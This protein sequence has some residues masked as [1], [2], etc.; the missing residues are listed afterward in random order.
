MRKMM[1]F[2]SAV[3][4]A[5]SLQAG[6][7]IWGFGG[8]ADDP[9]GA[10]GWMDS[11]ATALLYLGNVSFD[12]ASGWDLSSATF[13]TSSGYDVATDMGFG[14]LDT[15]NRS[16]SDAVNEAG[17][18]SY[19]L[20]LVDSAG[21]S[22]LASYTGDGKNYVIVTGTSEGN[23]IPSMSGGAN[24][25]YAALVTSAF[26]DSSAWQSAVTTGGGSGGGAPEPTSGLLLLVGAGLLGLRRKRA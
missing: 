13:I 24:Q 4:V 9:A 21:I 10:T 2:A 17:G 5:C 12:S 23:T 20:I 7:F 1:M 22:D 15:D 19:S 18:Q 11:G 25:T 3:A 16:T 26:V 6:S 8:G 14:N